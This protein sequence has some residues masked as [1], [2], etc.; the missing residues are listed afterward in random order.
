MAAPFNPV[1]II[2]H[3]QCKRIELLAIFAGPGNGKISET[4]NRKQGFGK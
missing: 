2:A 4:E 3:L 1:V